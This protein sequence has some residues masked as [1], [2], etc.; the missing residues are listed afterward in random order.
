LFLGE[1][2]TES[3]QAASPDPR[4]TIRQDWLWAAPFW[5]KWSGKLAVQSQAATDLVVQ[6]AQLSPGMDVLDLASGVGQPALTIAEKVGASGRVF[7]TDLIPEMLGAVREF[8]AARGFSNMEFHAADAEAL[9]FP[10][11]RFDRITCRFGLMFMPNIQ[12]AFA[13]MKRVLKPGGRVSFITWGPPQ[14]NPLFSV[15][16]DPFR[17][18]V[19]DPPPPPDA[20]HIFR[21]SDATKVAS[22]LDAAGF[23][24]VQALRHEVLWPWPGTP[25]DAWQGGSELAA[26]FRKVIAAVPVDKKEATIQ[27]AIEG[28]RKYSDGQSVN[29]TAS[30]IASTA[31]V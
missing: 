11:E 27:E 7:A 6:G 5:K 13:E 9:P 17:K 4:E 15:M 19:N 26:P 3:Q 23:R 28:L 14:E 25:E 18:Y 20:P 12:K 10:D 30:L 29:L 8:A 24:E 16:M 31:A 22:L 2:V 1:D 21:F